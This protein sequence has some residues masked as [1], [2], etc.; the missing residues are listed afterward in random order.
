MDTPSKVKPTNSPDDSSQPIEEPTT[1]T[2]PI[3]MDSD[4]AAQLGADRSAASPELS[5]ELLNDE[6]NP[7][8]M[9]ER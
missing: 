2:S 3:Q 5:S 6:E 1:V 7:A 9:L 4:G 8:S